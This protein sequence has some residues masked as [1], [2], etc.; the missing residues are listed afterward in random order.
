MA[1]KAVLEVGKK[2]EATVDEAS[3]AGDKVAV[4][5]VGETVQNTVAD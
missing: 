3:V 1:E 2:E 4:K 5:G